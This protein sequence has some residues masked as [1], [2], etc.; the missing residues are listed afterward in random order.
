[1][2]AAPRRRKMIMIRRSHKRDRKYFMSRVCETAANGG[3][4][5]TLRE[6]QVVTGMS[7]TSDEVHA[8]LE[9]VPNP[10]LPRHYPTNNASRLIASCHRPRQKQTPTSAIFACHSGGFSFGLCGVRKNAVPRGLRK[11]KN[12][13]R[14]F[15]NQNTPILAS[16]FAG[17]AAMV[18]TVFGLSV[19]LAVYMLA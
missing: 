7:A 19:M 3:C 1:M 2:N 12:S 10:R 9:R 18:Y 15:R 11:N 14:H 16:L 8:F 17:Y 6:R 4:D 5:G 13:F